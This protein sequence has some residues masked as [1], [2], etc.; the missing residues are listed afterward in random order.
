ML[1]QKAKFIKIL[2]QISDVIL[3]AACYVGSYVVRFLVL[4]RSPEDVSSSHFLLNEFLL[5]LVLW[6]IFSNLF[7]VYH[8]KRSK[9]SASDWPAVIYS[10]IALIIAYSFFHYVFKTHNLSRIFLAMYSGSSV[11]LIGISHQLARMYLN[12][13]RAKGWNQRN[14]LIIGA[15]QMGIE[16]A[17][18]FQRQIIY[19]Y[20]VTGFLD[21]KRKGRSI[22]KTSF[23]MLG[24]LKDLEKIIQARRIDRVIVVLPMKQLDTILTVIHTCEYL[25]IEVNFVPDIHQYIRFN[26]NTYEIE[27][28]PIISLRK[29]PI[30]SIGY[31]IFKRV[32][33]ILFSSLIIVLC[34]PLFLIIVILIRV[35]SKGPAFFRQK[36]LGLNRKEFT[37]Y[38]FRTM[39]MAS[40]EESDTA[41]TT[42][43]DK[44][45]T[46]IGRFLRKTSLDELPQF[47]N[48]LKGDMSVIGPRP[49]RPYFVKRFQKQIPKYMI[50]H[51]V[52]AGI[53]GWAQVHGFRGDTS[54]KKRVEYD[55]YYIE[56]WSFG[57]DFK[58]FWLTLWKG[59][60]G[61][62][63][64]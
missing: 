2:W 7:G 22:P 49:E 36:R 44:R 3:I 9:G 59:L 25:G 62:D 57:L 64:Y 33:D 13:I 46:P 39:I 12:L 26:T 58:I 32:F 18:S 23:Q 27:G 16:L 45:R 10:F 38:K 63:A 60:V 35:Q 43:R 4:K 47:W 21:D 51:Q 30:D 29:T 20:K 48:V 55:L 54:I 5:A 1:K 31:S 50:R 34:L 42:N 52:R 53:T 8:S 40:E 6:V 41:W 61:K 17:K 56:N 24:R 11:L 37:F 14:L 28:I 15:N 19:G